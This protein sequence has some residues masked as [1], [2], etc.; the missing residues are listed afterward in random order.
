MNRR[1]IKMIK[2][3]LRVHVSGVLIFIHV[4]VVLVLVGHSV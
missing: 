4:V 1:K 2:N 3:E